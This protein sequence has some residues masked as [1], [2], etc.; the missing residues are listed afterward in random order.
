LYKKMYKKTALIFPPQGSQFVGMGKDLYEHYKSAQGVFDEIDTALGFKLSKIMFEGPG[1]KLNLTQNAQPAILGFSLAALNALKEA[2]REPQQVDCA[3]GNSVGEWVAACAVGCLSL[4]DAARLLNLRGKL[5]QKAVPVGTGTMAAL[6]GVNLSTAEE[7]AYA[8]AQGEICVVSNHNSD[9]QQ[10]ISGH[11]AAI[12]RACRRIEL[13]S[14]AASAIK[15]PVTIPSHSPLMQPIIE[16]LQDAL[17]KAEIKKPKIPIMSSV[18]AHATDDPKDIHDQLIVSA[19]KPV[20]WQET[21]LAMGKRGV[22]QTIEC[23]GALLTELIQQNASEI[24]AVS[25]RTREDIH[26]L[27]PS[28]VKPPFAGMGEFCP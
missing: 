27:R 7:I 4:S 1:E 10:V 26:Q 19:I 11:A 6:I 18:T 25:I 12:E 17:A 24:E 23:G 2:G 16:P 20:L 3:A 8:A 5:M 9:T 28:L 15:L 13:T 14:K 22:T 21:L